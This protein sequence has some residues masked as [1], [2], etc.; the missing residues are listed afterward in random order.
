[1]IASNVSRARAHW[2]SRAAARPTTASAPGADRLSGNSVLAR[3]AYP[4]AS[5]H[6]FSSAATCAIASRSAG[7]MTGS[8]G[9]ASSGAA[10]LV[11]SSRLP[12][13]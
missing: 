1:M 12:W 2:P 10:S 9:P 7:V 8:R 6:L 4:R 13:A 11:N 5:G 3:S